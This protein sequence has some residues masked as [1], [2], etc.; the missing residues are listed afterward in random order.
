MLGTLGFMEYMK[1]KGNSILRSYK[2]QKHGLHNEKIVFDQLSWCWYIKSDTHNLKEEIVY[3]VHGVRG[4]SPW[5]TGSKE[6]HYGGRVWGSKGA[7]FMVGRRTQR[8][9]TS[10]TYISQRLPVTHWLQ[11]DSISQQNLHLRA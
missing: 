3:L 7:H 4:F 8:K 1:I 6:Q 2:T 5:L 9:S 10:K 11:L